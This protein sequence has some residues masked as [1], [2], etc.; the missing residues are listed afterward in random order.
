MAFVEP[1]ETGEGAV[2]PLYARQLQFAARKWQKHTMFVI[3]FLF[4]TFFSH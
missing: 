4:P 2:L 3:L 1:E